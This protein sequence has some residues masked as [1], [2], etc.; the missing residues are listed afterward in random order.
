MLALVDSIKSEL[1]QWI[2]ALSTLKMWIQLRVPRVEDGNNFGV[3]VQEEAI[4]L[5]S[6]QEDQAFGVLESIS[7]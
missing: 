1:L 6:S 7:K 5:V 2:E 3:A 4:Q